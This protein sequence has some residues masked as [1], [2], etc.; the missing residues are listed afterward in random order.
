VQ[1]GRYFAKLDSIGAG[2]EFQRA[3]CAPKDS[4]GDA[5]LTISDWVQAGRY[6]VG[7]DPAVTAGGP[8]A[9]ALM[10]HSSSINSGSAIS[11]EATSNSKVTTVADANEPGVLL[12]RLEAQGTEN[13]L[14]FSLS[15]DPKTVR[16]SSA[17]LE[18]DAQGAQLI[19]N[20]LQGQAGK[21]GIALALPA[22][23]SFPSKATTLLRLKFEPIGR[24]Y[25][26]STQ[27]RFSDDLI[28]R[29][30]VDAFANS[31]PASYAENLLLLRRGATTRRDTTPR[32]TNPR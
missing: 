12:I 24:D 32:K 14:A 19:V 15:F 4:K 7:L 18:S 9:A 8:T 17:T 22:G 11:A 21:I 10:A 2:N 31:V 30:L 27:V 20:Q 3:D 28:R 6:A 29:A 25:P 5:A 16:Y 1:I 26:N 23:K 13:A